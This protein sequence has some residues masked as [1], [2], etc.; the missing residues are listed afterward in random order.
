MRKPIMPKKPSRILQT[1]T[2]RE[3]ARSFQL[4]SW[5]SSDEAKR[6]FGIICHAVNVQNTTVDIMGT[7]DTPFAKLVPADTET[8]TQFEFRIST[9]DAKANWTTVSSAVIFFGSE[10]RIHG[11]H[12]HAILKRNSENRH[13]A[14]RYRNAQIED[15]PQNIMTLR[16]DLHELSQKIS[17]N[18]DLID[19][20]F[21]EIWRKQ[22]I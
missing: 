11:K 19:R 15:I 3:R 14:F 20:R 13:P 18:A 16:D 5:Y 10:F 1:L 9:E 21:K 2:W 22:N 6:S 7:E 17:R 8:K 12:E 4:E